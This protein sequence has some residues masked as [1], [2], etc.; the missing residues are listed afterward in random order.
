MGRLGDPFAERRADV[1]GERLLVEADE[2]ARDDQ[3]A[4]D[5][6]RTL[7]KDAAE[8]EPLCRPAFVLPGKRGEPAHPDGRGTDDQNKHRGGRRRKQCADR[9]GRGD[10]A[11]DRDERRP[12]ETGDRYRQ[13]GEDEEGIG[14]GRAA[15]RRREKEGR[16]QPRPD[17][18][19]N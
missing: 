19:E 15:Q 3:S 6:E 5:D 8:R 11:D 9:Q 13:A 10:D 17:T 16:R 7:E 1:L 14:E 4:G 12:G 18:Q 2:G